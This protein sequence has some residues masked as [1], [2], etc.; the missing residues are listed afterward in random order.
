MTLCIKTALEHVKK[1]HPF[2]I[3]AIVILTDHLHCILTLPADDLDYPLRIRLVKAYF[4]KRYF[5]AGM[6]KKPS[7]TE[8]REKAVWQR[9]YWENVIRDD[10]DYRRHVEYIH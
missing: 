9:R 6:R 5:D 2:T 8:S 3:D 1:N 10:E 7:G 4:S